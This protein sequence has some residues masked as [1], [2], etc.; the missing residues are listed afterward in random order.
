MVAEK[1]NIGRGC[2]SFR[3]K[4]GA[5]AFYVNQSQ[6]KKKKK[7]QRMDYNTRLSRGTPD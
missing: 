3:G 4:S 6:N 5:K 2:D 1:E 7:N